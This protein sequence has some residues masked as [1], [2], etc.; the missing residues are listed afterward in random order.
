MRVSEVLAAFSGDEK[1]RRNM[2]ES[3]GVNIF[4]ELLFSDIEPLQR[5]ATMVIGNFARDE[6]ATDDII[7]RGGSEQTNTS[8]FLTFFSYGIGLSLIVIG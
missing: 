5:N 2:I 1:S 7:Q 3:G 8:P 6:T 4:V